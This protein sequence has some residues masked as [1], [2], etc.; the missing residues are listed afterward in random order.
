MRHRYPDHEM[1][2]ER[3]IRRWRVVLRSEPP[4]E[5]DL[6]AI[7]ASMVLLLQA[8]RRSLYGMLVRDLEALAPSV[9]MQRRGAGETDVIIE[10]N[11]AGCVGDCEM[12]CLWTPVRLLNAVWGVA[13]LNDQPAAEWR[14]LG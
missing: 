7:S 9:S 4:L 10:Y 12:I 1:R 13:L 3:A 6:A 14:P 11:P 2:D 8:Q 5:A